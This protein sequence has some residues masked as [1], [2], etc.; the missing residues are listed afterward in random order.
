MSRGE[1]DDGGDLKVMLKRAKTA[2]VEK[3]FQY[4][5]I[6]KGAA[7]G[8]LL[9]SKKKIAPKDIAA[10]K[11]KCSGKLV[12]RGN[13]FGED[14]KMVFQTPKAPGATFPKLVKLLAKREAQLAVKPEFRVAAI[15]GVEELKADDSANGAP[16]V[17]ALRKRMLEIEAEFGRASSK[18]GAPVVELKQLRQQTLDAITK[19]KPAEAAA[20]LDKLEDLVDDTLYSDDDAPQAT[21]ST[22]LAKRLTAIAADYQRAVSLKG[23]TAAQMQSLHKTVSRNIE[24]GAGAPSDAAEALK[25]LE[26]LVK[27]TLKKAA[28]AKPAPKKNAEGKSDLVRRIT[29]MKANLDLAIAA[30]GPD[31]WQIRDL[32][33]QLRILVEKPDYWAAGKLL[34][35]LEPLVKKGATPGTANE[36]LDDVF[37]SVEAHCKRWGKTLGENKKQPRDYLYQLDLMKSDVAADRK[38]LDSVIKHQLPGATGPQ[39]AQLREKSKMLST[40]V[41]AF[42]AKIEEARTEKIAEA[43]KAAQTRLTEWKSTIDSAG[44]VVG[45]PLLKLIEQIESGMATDLAN[46]NACD[47]ANLIDASLVKAGLVTLR[48]RYNA[49]LPQRKTADAPKKK[50][51]VEGDA[52]PLPTEEEEGDILTIYKNNNKNWFDIKKK[53]QD[54]TISDAV[55]KRLWAFR[56]K[57]VFNYMAT[58]KTKYG[59]EKKNGWDAVGSTNLES[60]IDISV[61]QHYVPPGEKKI[62]KYDYQIVKEFNDFFFA[63]FGAQPGVMFDTNLYASAK[64]MRNLDDRP[65]SP[66]KKA[67]TSMTQ[68]GQD[69]G[70]LMKQRR[71]MTWE[72]YDEYTDTVLKQMKKDG[73]DE[74]ALEITR[75][76][77]EEADSLYQV[78]TQKMLDNAQKLITKVP[79]ANRT[80]EQTKAIKMIEEAMANAAKATP[81]EGQ[82]ILL[83]AITDMSH[84]QDVTMWANNEMYTAAIEEV[85]TIE[86]DADDLAKEI[87]TKNLGPESPQSKKLA[88]LLARAR[89]LGADAVFF[90]NEAYHSEGPFKHIV[91][92]TQGAE[93]DVEAD[94][95]KK[96]APKKPG[97][98]G[99]KFKELTDAER[100]KMISDE[101][102]KRRNALSLQQCLQSFNEQLGDFLKDLEH[103]EKEEFPGMGFYRS[104]KYLSRLFDAASLLKSKAPKLNVALDF[105]QAAQINDGI[106]AS[107]KGALEFKDGPNGVPLQGK[108]LQDEI[109][110]FAIA[111]IRRMFNVSTLKDLGAKFKAIG[112]SVNAQLRKMVADEMKAGKED[113]KAYFQN[114]GK[115]ETWGAKK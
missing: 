41:G 42:P 55:M 62:A 25:S 2:K 36:I 74:R 68:A 27:S 9:V 88:T 106:L 51:V 115:S 101:Q 6:A 75:K 15:E 12:A 58:L 79:V 80:D 40:L 4:A 23:E 94:Y 32:S 20:L 38:T 11:K 17:I 46:L 71:Y 44:A 111:E 96:N 105:A 100:K 64:P 16:T 87:E 98:K 114:A 30:K 99:K 39:A 21:G 37:K 26:E 92:A 76:Q 70:A 56:Q 78:A 72:E 19:S 69:V 67:M 83:K 82:K 7:E 60:D 43:V 35:R 48:N 107:R 103:Y 73:A 47:A 104:S 57:V 93:S 112:T 10:A 8:V 3:P 91:E 110:A 89:D 63:K 81:V 24:T 22:E 52:P 84:F 18:K 90:A 28:A 86:T 61:T 97:D 34:D 31:V 95:D 33:D 113:E 85:R 108:A 77:F 65:D 45:K 14:G 102:A 50:P 5:L 13:V 66:A 53:F 29:A 109:E 59:F 1:D 54:G 49:G